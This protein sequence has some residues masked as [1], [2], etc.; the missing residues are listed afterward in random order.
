MKVQFSTTPVICS[1]NLHKLNLNNYSSRQNF[2]NAQITNDSFSFVSRN[3][4]NSVSFGNLPAPNINAADTTG[5]VNGAK[6]LSLGEGNKVAFIAAEMPPYFKIGGVATVLNDY[7]ELGD[8]IMPYYNGAVEFNSDT[9]KPTGNV[10]IHTLKNGTP[11]FTNE[12]LTKKS[13]QQI[14]EEGKYFEL[15]EVAKSTM[16]WG[17]NDSDN[18]AMYKVKGTNDYMV[19]CDE[20]AKM[21]KPYQSPLG[22]QYAYNSSSPITNNGWNGTPEAKSNKAMATLLPQSKLNYTHVVCSD[23]QTAYFPYYMREMA[24][25]DNTIK[26]LKVTYVGHNLG[27]GYCGETSAQ[28]M[29]VNLGLNKTHISAIEQDQSFFDAFKNNSTEDYFKGFLHPDVIDASGKPSP[30]MLALRMRAEGSLGAFTTVSEGYAKSLATNPRVAPHIHEVWKGLYNDDRKVNGI[31]NPLND[32]NLTA[33]KPVGLKGY[34]APFEITH[35]DGTKEMIQEFK[36]FS[37]EM[38]FDEMSAVKNENKLNLFNRLSGKYNQS[39][40]L[41]GLSGRKVSLIGTIDQSWS[42]KIRNGEKVDL[43]VSWGRGDFQKGLDTVLDSFNQFGRTEEGKN[44]VLVLGGELLDGGADKKSILGKL[45]AMLSDDVFKGRLVFMDGFAPGTALSSAGDAA[46]LPS[47]FAPCELTDLEAPKYF[48]TPVVANTQGMAQK[49][50]DPRVDTEKGIARAYKTL[51]EFYMS[52]DEL[53]KESPFYKTKYNELIEEEKRIL[54]LRGVKSE[55]IAAVAKENVEN[56]DKFL[57]LVQEAA[58]DLIAKELNNALLH[59]AQADKSLLE[60]LYINQKNMRTAWDQNGSLHPDG[61]HSLQMYKDIHIDCKTDI[62][63]REKTFFKIPDSVKKAMNKSK[64]NATENAGDIIKDAKGS[65]WGKIAI[66][67]AG[68]A[69]GAISVLALKDS[70]EKKKAD[71][72]AT[73]AAEPLRQDE[74]AVSPASIMRTPS[75]PKPFAA[76]A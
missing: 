10:K 57:K 37:P 26:S 13:I 7:K 21:P 76:L 16:Q 8:R 22:Q 43:L 58:D 61:R 51:N 23:S 67:A 66:A 47:R 18:I 63:K 39:E 70:K 35:A 65:K 6:K 45:N 2:I 42:S 60:H 72:N 11:I 30:T 73:I 53:E 9:G 20:T 36:I 15:E 32:P 55:K 17:Q 33:Y 56:S 41:T 59:R 24:Q 31:L 27:P 1:T 3:T 14:I 40:V 46:I 62:S 44:S 29:A 64:D 25:H 4:A 12:D 19:Y 54:T 52:F 48:C 74:G 38:S 28:N 5:L 49:N 75:E 68:L 71:N 69:V 34:A 50:P